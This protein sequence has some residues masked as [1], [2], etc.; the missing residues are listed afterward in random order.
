MVKILKK[1]GMETS[2]VVLTV[3]HSKTLKVQTRPLVVYK[4][5][6]VFT[7]DIAKEVGKRVGCAVVIND[8]LSDPNNPDNFFAF[9]NQNTKEFFEAVKKFQ[10]Q[11][12]IDIHG[13]SEIGPML[14]NPRHD[15]VR[16]FRYWKERSFLSRRPDVDIE[17]KRKHGYVTCK[18]AIVVTLAKILA[19]SNFVVD[20]EAVFPGGFV[21]ER[22][23]NL[24]TDAVAIEVNRKIRDDPAKRQQL[25]DCLVQFIEVFRGKKI[26]EVIDAQRY[27]DTEEIFRQMQERMAQQRGGES[28]RTRYIG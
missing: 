18:G 20:F 15:G 19:K 13:L 14:L 23:S 2:D 10:P 8:S 28:E 11:L 3:A 17:Y 12:V 9:D 22:T 24:H 4:D 7:E 25:A 27:P 5:E 26:E 16:Y 6:E 21:I 1:K